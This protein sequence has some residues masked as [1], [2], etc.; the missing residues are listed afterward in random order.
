M[1]WDE[2]GSGGGSAKVGRGETTHQINVTDAYKARFGI[3]VPIRFVEWLM[4]F[5]DDWTKAS[6]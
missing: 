4:G 5:P 2:P 3:P 1:V 6:D